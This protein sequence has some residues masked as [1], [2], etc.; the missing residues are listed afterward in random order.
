[1]WA[2]SGTRW[3]PT[4]RRRRKAGQAPCGSSGAEAEAGL[5]TREDP[6]LGEI[7]VDKNGM[8]VYRFK[9]DKAW[10]KPVS[11][12]TGECLEKW[13]LVEP[14]DFADTKGIQEKGYM[15]FD[16]TDGK[17]KQQTINCS[18]IY[19]FMRRQGSGRHQRPGCRRHLVRRAARRKA[20]RRVGIAERPPQG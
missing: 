20:G 14:V 16:R 2:A 9:K 11:N 18:P 5:S 8:T 1:M 15:I 4:A 10:P 19:T 17:G 3:P 13:P 6:K 12:C 7:V